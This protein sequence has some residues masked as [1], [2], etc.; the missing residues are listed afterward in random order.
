ML[1]VKERETWGKMFLQLRCGSSWKCHRGRRG[2]RGFNKNKHLCLQACPVRH[3]LTR[4]ITASHSKYTRLSH[5]DDSNYWFLTN[6]RNA[7]FQHI[8]YCVEI[9]SCC[10]NHIAT[11]KRN[12]KNS[13][14]RSLSSYKRSYEGEKI[15]TKTE[16][17]TLHNTRAELLISFPEMRALRL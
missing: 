3:V 13:E 7:R 15:K 2:G 5:T 14:C 9:Q 4:H 17:R 16:T 10:S 8:H 11:L 12:F 6:T 1:I